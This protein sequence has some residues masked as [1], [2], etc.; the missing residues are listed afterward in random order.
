[1]HFIHGIKLAKINPYFWGCKT[2]FTP[3]AREA[4]QFARVGAARSAHSHN[5]CSRLQQCRVLWGKKHTVKRI[6]L[7]WLA[8]KRTKQESNSQK[9]SCP[10][11]YSQLPIQQETKIKKRTKGKYPKVKIYEFRTSGTDS[12]LSVSAFEAIVSRNLLIQYPFSSNAHQK[13]KKLG[14]AN[15]LQVWGYIIIPNA[16]RKYDVFDRKTKRYNLPQHGL[17]CK[18]PHWYQSI[19][20]FLIHRRKHRIKVRNYLANP[21]ASLHLQTC[22]RLY[23]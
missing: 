23:K 19:N 12:L 5:R 21:S 15:T 18:I 2:A 16:S 11:K 22:T 3:I 4:I 8:E 13:A 6:S 20:M 17:N 7:A 10:L 14:W 9:W 1:M